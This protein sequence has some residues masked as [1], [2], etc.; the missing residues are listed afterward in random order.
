MSAADGFDRRRFIAGALSLPAGALLVGCGGNGEPR[1]RAAV[2]DSRPPAGGGVRTWEEV[3]GLFDLDPEIAHLSAFILAPHSRVVREAVAR[4]RDGLDRSPRTYLLENEQLE[5]EAADAAA[6]NLRTDPGL[7]ALTDST[8]MGLGLVFGSLRLERGDEVIVSR[9]DH[10]VA[11]LSAQYAADRVGATVKAIDLYPPAAPERASVRE[12][13]S[14]FEAALRPSTRA[15]LVTWVHSASGLRMPLR[16]IAAVV[17]RAN[18][19]RAEEH[20]A[21]LIVD[22]AHGL[23]AGPAHVQDLGCDFL[24][25][26]C[27]KWLLGPRGTGIVWGTGS[28]WRRVAPIIPSFRGAGEES[29]PGYR[30]TPGGYHSFEHRWALAESFDLHTSIGPERIAARIAALSDGLREG[31]R[32]VRGVTVHAPPEEGTHSGVVTFSVRGLDGAETV[33]KLWDESRVQANVGPYEVQLARLGTCWLNTED[34]VDAA[35]RAVAS[36]A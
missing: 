9:L 19:G 4:H 14:A 24:I 1:D 36:I 34:E 16:E 7:I 26:G 29:P 5:N 6:R 13:V 15:V 32:R 12:L 18:R 27:H 25:A 35:V 28:A 31:L 22:A 2:A 20:R 3:R 10:F 33:R 11:R 21:L 17:E 23:G 30:M 8:T